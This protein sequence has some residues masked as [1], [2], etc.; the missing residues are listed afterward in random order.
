MK[1]EKI[2][3][4]I[5]QNY[6]TFAHPTTKFWTIHFME[7]LLVATIL[8]KNWTLNKMNYHFTV[9]PCLLSLWIPTVNSYIHNT[10]NSIVDRF[11]PNRVVSP[12]TPHDPANDDVGAPD[13]HPR[14]RP[15]AYSSPGVSLPR[16]QAAPLHKHESRLLFSWMTSS[17][18]KL[19]PTN[20]SNSPSRWK[21][22]L[23]PTVSTTMQ[24]TP[25]KF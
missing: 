1:W 24:N 22:N 6:G 8:N 20:L 3:I 2:T 11:T 15:P 23:V 13:R 14:P 9:N 4:R 10:S 17:K 7:N 12:R 21:F 18:Y 25:R 19:V 5:H 16:L